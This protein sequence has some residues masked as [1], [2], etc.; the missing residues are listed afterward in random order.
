MS[1]FISSSKSLPCPICGDTS[2]K[3]EI[4]QLDGMCLCETKIDAEEGDFVGTW[5]CEKP[6]S[7]DSVIWMDQGDPEQYREINI[8]L[9]ITIISVETYLI[10][11]ENSPASCKKGAS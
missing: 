3:C 7:D 10:F 9:N 4:C 1:E 11:Q 6:F 5:Q 8:S 2:G